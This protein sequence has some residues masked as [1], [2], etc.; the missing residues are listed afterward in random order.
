MATDIL[1]AIADALD[2]TAEVTLGYAVKKGLRLQPFNTCR[3]ASSHIQRIER[4]LSKVNEHKRMNYFWGRYEFIIM[5]KEV[6]YDVLSKDAVQTYWH[7]L[8]QPVQTLIYHP[9]GNTVTLKAKA[10]ESPA[11]LPEIRQSHRAPCHASG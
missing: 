1:K 5:R 9:T 8:F 6:A 3:E 2:E 11:C 7:R 10:H 4:K